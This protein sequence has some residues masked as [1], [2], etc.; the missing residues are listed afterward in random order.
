MNRAQT[1]VLVS[2]VL[3]GS[4]GAAIPLLGFFA[5]TFAYLVAHM[6][7]LGMRDLRTIA[8][9]TAGTLLVFYTVIEMFLRVQLPRGILF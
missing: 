1:N 7:F 5:S 2:L 4:Y 3:L 9:V 8:A 6:A